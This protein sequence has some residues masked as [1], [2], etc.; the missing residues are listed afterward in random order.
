MTPPASAWPRLTVAVIHCQVRGYPA[1]CLKSLGA[2]RSTPG[3]EFLLLHG[4][5]DPIG[6]AFPEVRRIEMDAGDRA[7]AR[8]RAVAEAQGEFVL[9]VSSDTTASREAVERLLAFVAS[10]QERTAASAQLLLENG[11]RRRT[12]FRAPSLWTELNPFPGLRRALASVVRDTRLPLQGP[13]RRAKAL[14]ATFLL[15]RRTTLGDIGAFAEGYRFA[16]EDIEWCRR[17]RRC[18]GRLFIVPEARAFKLAPQQRG[19]LS[20][21]ARVTLERAMR[22]CV[23]RTHGRIH[24]AVYGMIRRMKHLA[25][26]PVAAALDV[27][28]GGAEPSIRRAAAVEWALLTDWGPPPQLPADAESHVRWEEVF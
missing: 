1:D 26:W 16:F 24:T 28:C 12:D 20:P 19:G 21:S 23:Q 11:M 14:H 9:L 10:Q 15:A 22:R 7:V 17:L 18:G 2:D 4:G 3:I 25:L 8:N 5:G 27:M 6:A 13:P